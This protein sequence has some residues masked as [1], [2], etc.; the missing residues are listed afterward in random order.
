MKKQGKTAA[1]AGMGRLGGICSAARLMAM[2]LSAALLLGIAACGGGGNQAAATTTAAPPATSAADETTAAPAGDAAADETTASADAATTAAPAATD[3]ATEPAG[4]FAEHIKF[5]M[6]VI[7]AEKAGLDADGNIE[8]HLQWLYDKFNI[9]FEFYP[10]TWDNYIDQTRLWL[11]SNDA[12]DLIMFDVAAVRYSE[13]VQSVNDGLLKPYT[14]YEQ[15]PNLKAKMDIA[16]T[17]RQF[18]VNGELYAWPAFLDS[19]ANKFRMMTAPYYR[20]DWAQAAGL[21]QADHIY[22]W[23]EWYTLVKTVV[24]QD[25]AGNGQTIGLI[26]IDWSLPKYWGPG[27]IS[28]YILQYG[29]DGAGG[30]TWGPLLPESLDAIKLIKQMYDDGLIWSDQVM[31]KAEDTENNFDGGRLFAVSSP[32]TSPGGMRDVFKRFKE[33]NPESNPEELIDFAYFEGPDGKIL[34]YETNDHWSQEAMNANLSDEAAERWKTVLDYL[35]SDEGYYYIALGI[36]G[37]DWHYDASGE[38]VADWAQ[39]EDGTYKAPMLNA[40]PWARLAAS[41]DNADLI[42]PNMPE[43]VRKLYG[44]LVDIVLDDSKVRQIPVDVDLAFFTGE[45]FGSVGTLEADIYQE[46][47]GLLIS[48]DAEGDWNRW[49]ESKRPVVQP[50]IDEINAALK[51]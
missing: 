21:Y 18:I 45:A 5:T 48:N 47:A 49:V 46:V 12:P 15:Y 4:E 42:K 25:P 10:L 8:P 1:G 40:W 22:T 26:G 17:G 24:E 37:V 43:H 50:A 2:C 32:S 36:P 19:S 20:K 16:S 9:E 31:V 13:F 3:A 14:N 51:K 11:A 38:P 6:S 29:P 7:D 28:P 34:S 35:V 23:D 39:N 30:Y 44:E 27:S 41:A 33:T